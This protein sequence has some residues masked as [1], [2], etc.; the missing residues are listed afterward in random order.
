[1]VLFM[2]EGEFISPKP[3]DFFVATK[4]EP[5][6]DFGQAINLDESENPAPIV[7]AYAL[8]AHDDIF[9]SRNADVFYGMFVNGV[10]VSNKHDW[11]LPVNEDKIALD[12]CF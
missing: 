8:R 11:S 2:S 3:A 10:E 1:M 6:L 12:N 7:A 4:Q 9:V 5:R